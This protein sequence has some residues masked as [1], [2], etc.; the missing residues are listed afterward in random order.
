WD[1]P[2]TS[3]IPHPYPADR[4][5]P[6]DPDAPPPPDDPGSDCAVGLSPPG[7][8]PHHHSGAVAEP[9]NRHADRSAD[10]QP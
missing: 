3:E 7:T 10:R 5:R 9:A 2:L 6:P 8:D 4:S 1:R